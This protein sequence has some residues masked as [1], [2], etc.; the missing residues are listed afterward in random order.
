MNTPISK[1]SNDL[2]QTFNFNNDGQKMT[3]K[4]V[5]D[6]IG[7]TD[8]TI[9]DT[10]KKLFPE[11]IAEHGKTTFLNET[12]VTA[13]KLQIQSGGKRNSKDNLGVQKVQTKLE[14]SLLIRQAMRLQDELIEELEAENQELKSTV[15]LLVHDS[16]KTY[17]ASEMATELGFKS[18][19]E[20]NKKLHDLRIQYKV[21]DTWKLYSNYDGLGYTESKNGTTEHGFVFYD[22]RWTGKGRLF[23]LQTFNINI[24][25]QI[26]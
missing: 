25:N 3:V 4:Q 18:A 10:I 21:N 14:K 1:K 20:L 15:G 12:Q 5:A 22:T 6:I 8:Q 9:R 13:I 2:Q 26:N 24:D 16:Q 7:V 11:I 19:Q 17:T 23:L